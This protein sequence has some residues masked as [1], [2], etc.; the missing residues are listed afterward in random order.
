MSLHLL[1]VAII[2]E[3]SSSSSGDDVSPLLY[4]PSFGEKM[5][6]S[7]YMYVYIH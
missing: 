3:S 5:L 4:S 1:G 6:C 2:V 7:C